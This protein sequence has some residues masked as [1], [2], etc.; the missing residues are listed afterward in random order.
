MLY[1][2]NQVRSSLEKYTLKLLQNL[3]K[4]DRWTT[5]NYSVV[6]GPKYV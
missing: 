3:F 6:K 2:M 4:Y 5:K 1:I